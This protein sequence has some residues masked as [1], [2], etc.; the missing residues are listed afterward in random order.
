MMSQLPTFRPMKKAGPLRNGA[1]LNK[2]TV[3]HAV[4]ADQ[5]YC[6]P[7]LCGQ[8]PAIQWSDCAGREVTCPR[9]L[10]RLEM[11]HAPTC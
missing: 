2:G 3:I 4:P 6:G 5:T 1:E 7:A 10:R 9:C 11:N 8:Q